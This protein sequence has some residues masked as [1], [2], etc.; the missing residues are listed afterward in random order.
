MLQ[1]GSNRFPSGLGVCPQGF[2]QPACL[3]HT[4]AGLAALAVTAAGATPPLD[5]APYPPYSDPNGTGK[6]SRLV[7]LGARSFSIWKLNQGPYDEVC[8]WAAGLLCGSSNL[9]VAT[10]A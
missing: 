10:P 9:C 1:G 3:I 8:R 4:S 6:F 7:S 2:D 5:K